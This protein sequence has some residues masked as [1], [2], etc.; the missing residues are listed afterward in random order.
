MNP[1]ELETLLRTHPELAPSRDLESRIVRAARPRSRA[2]LPAAAALLFIV[3]VVASVLATLSTPGGKGKRE[4]HRPF[5]IRFLKEDGKWK[6][7]PPDFHDDLLLS[8]ERGIAFDGPADTPWGLIRH[9][10]RACV[11]AE[12]PATEWRIG[13]QVLKVAA[14]VPPRQGE[15]DRVIL[16]EIRIVM[17]RDPRGR[18]VRTVGD[19]LPVES[20]EE[21]FSIILRMEADY[22][23]AGK[24]VVPIFID[25]NGDVAWRDVADILEK[26]RKEGFE[27]FVLDPPPALF[28]R[29]E[30]QQKLWPPDA[31]LYPKL[32][33][34]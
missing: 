16:E 2:M 1:E 23:K 28:K 34:K 32:E 20:E 30:K 13:E 18:L 3:G 27:E 29:E 12:I 7:S 21:L 24:T 4:P 6:V 9:V 25:A 17:R 26:C 11:K 33:D 31:R 14:Y 8:K 10:R 5:L 19:R 15:P 22:R